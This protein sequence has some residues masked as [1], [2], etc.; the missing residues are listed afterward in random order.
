MEKAK[1]II[2]ITLC[3]ILF[4]CLV[5]LLVCLLVIP[6]RTKEFMDVVIDYMNRP[7]PIVGVSLIVFLLFIYK[8]FSLTSFGKK[9]INEAKQ[10]V[11]K[12][13]NKFNALSKENEKLKEEQV[14][15][16]NKLNIVVGGIDTRV[17]FLLEE[18]KKVAET[19]PNAKVNAL[20]S[21]IES[22]Y[23][24]KKEQ[25]QDY[26]LGAKKYSEK[27]IDELENKVNE[28]TIMLKK[29]LDDEEEEKP[30]D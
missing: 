30:N 16:E 15:Y 21:E 19:I 5:S 7:L 6:E 8:L 23:S 10:E 24:Q 29:V 27:D 1:R 20:V 2:K 9:A 4:G 12:I 13:T 3:A 11:V 14:E 18:L 28:I 22:G 17:D 26:V 25:T